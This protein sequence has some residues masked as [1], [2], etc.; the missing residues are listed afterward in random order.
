MYLIAYNTGEK[1][2]TKGAKKVAKNAKE[3][4]AGPDLP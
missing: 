4:H 3:S 2:T 1:L